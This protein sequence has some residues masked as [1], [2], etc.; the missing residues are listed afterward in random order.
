MNLKVVTPLSNMDN[1]IPL[2]E[3]GADEFFCGILP[4]EWLDKYNVTMP[5]NR[6]EYLLDNCNICTMSSV[7]ILKKMI[8]SYKVNVKVTLNSLYYIKEQYPLILNLI[9]MLQDCGINT[10]IIADVALICYLR[11]KN[12]DCNIHLSGECGALN[13]YTLDFFEPLNIE[14]FIFPGKESIDNIRTSIEQFKTGK[15]KEFESFILND[16]CMFLGAFCNTVHCDE[17]PHSCHLPTKTVR[18]DKNSIK[19][20]DIY[21]VLKLRNQLASKT[22]I[23]NRKSYYNLSKRRADTYNFAEKGCGIC[24]MHKLMRCGITH[25]KLVGRGHN[26]DMVKRDLEFLKKGIDI[27]NTS[28]NSEEFEEKIKLNIFNNKCPTTCFYN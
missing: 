16:W 24:K 13:H 2:V 3:A 14:R 8:E 1:Y 5:L 22:N 21:H 15:K 27:M 4:F 23:V 9:K 19:Y 11:E 10:F 6:R 7:R 26:L 17:I 28:S 12:I 20:K 25:I 18:I